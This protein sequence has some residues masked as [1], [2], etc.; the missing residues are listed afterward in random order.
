VI[1]EPRKIKLV[2]VFI[3]SPC[4][5]PEVMEWDAMTFD[6]VIGIPDHLI[7]L[8]RNLYAGQEEKA[9]TENGTTHW[10]QVKKGVCQYCH[11]DFLCPFHYRGLECKSMKSRNTWSNRQIWPWNME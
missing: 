10:F 11:P 1:L 4:I 7:C 9:R 6:F 5:C 2:T 3:V 8:L